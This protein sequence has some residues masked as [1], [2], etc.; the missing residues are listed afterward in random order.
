[1]AVVDSL[2]V[3]PAGAVF[4]VVAVANPEV[5]MPGVVVPLPFPVNRQE[6][7]DIE[8]IKQFNH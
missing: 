5:A 7:P 8:E 4:P 1:M 3:P 6:S 2:S